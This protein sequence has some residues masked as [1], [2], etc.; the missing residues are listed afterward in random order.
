MADHWN[1]A[2]DKVFLVTMELFWHQRGAIPSTS[3]R[4]E[5]SHPDSSAGRDA[6]V[7]RGWETVPSRE[8]VLKAAQDILNQVHG[9]CLQSMHELGSIRE[10]DRVLVQTLMAEF[11]RIQL[12]IQEDVAKSLLALRADLQVSSVALISD[13]TQAVDLLPADPRSAPLRAPLWKF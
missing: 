8:Q 5:V 9:L 10:V 12:I 4:V 1:V 7:P 11:L 6:V 3:T 13:V 2:L